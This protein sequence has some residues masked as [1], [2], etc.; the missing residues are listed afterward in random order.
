MKKGDVVKMSDRNPNHLGHDVDA[1]AGMEGIVTDIYED[2]AFC[3]DCGNCAL[4][5]PMRDA[6]KNKKDGVW[7]WLNGVH[8]FHKRRN[9][10]SPPTL[11]KKQY[12]KRLFKFKQDE[13]YNKNS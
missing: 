7:I 1:Y 3:L 4:V 12:F 10:E 9:A 2:G 13:Y 5:V 6:F 11:V 8:I